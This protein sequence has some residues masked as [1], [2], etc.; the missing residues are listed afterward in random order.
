MAR[1]SL[2]RI[3]RAAGKDASLQRTLS[4]PVLAAAI[5]VLCALAA[6]RTFLIGAAPFAVVG[7]FCLVAAGACLTAGLFPPRPHLVLVV[8]IA[9]AAS[10][11]GELLLLKIAAV[12]N[13][14]GGDVALELPR[15][16]AI[17]A[18]LPLFFTS[19]LGA[20]AGAA[21]RHWLTGSSRR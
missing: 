5:V 12:R 13:A 20:A 6:G 8:A 10:G 7:L 4:A 21:A 1:L 16:L 17:C 9:L 18:L 14:P 19:V 3:G 15:W 11:T 2:Q